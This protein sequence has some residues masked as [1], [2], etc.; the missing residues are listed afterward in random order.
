MA[1]ISK[2][3]NNIRYFRQYNLVKTYFDRDY[4][5]STY[6]DV[7]VSGVNPVWHYLRHGWLEWRNPSQFFD[8]KFYYTSFPDCGVSGMNPFY[9]YLAYGKAEGRQAIRE[10]TDQIKIPTCFHHVQDNTFPMAAESAEHIMVIV[11][12]EHNEMSGGIFSFFS[13]AKATYNLRHK[14]NYLVLLMTRPNPRNETY[15]RQ[16]NFRNSEDVFRFDQ[17]TRCKKAKTIYIHI[18]EYAAP[19]FVDY[20]DD[21]TYMFLKSRER[22]YINILNQKIDIMPNKE[23]LNTLRALADELTQSVAHHAY[24]G[25]KFAARYDTPMLLLPAYTDLSEYCSIPPEEKENLIIYSP[26]SSEYKDTVINTIK[27][28]LPNYQLQEIKGITFET[29]MDLATR[30]KYSITFG[31]GFDGYLAQ[32]IHQ[33]GVSF[34]VYN[35]EFFPTSDILTFYNIFP[36]SDSMIND[37][38]DR[39]KTLDSDQDLYKETNA[40]MIE[41]YSKLYSKDDYLNKIEMLINR[42]F[43]IYPLHLIENYNRF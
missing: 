17:I 19:S 9:H 40:R 15:L 1:Y 16:R 18:P 20:M 12:P 33:G 10:A 21:K 23:E 3:I 2:V 29:Y 25:Q 27:D 41:L 5:L 38:V 4:Y 6:E 11:V 30:C 36:T 8:T 34:A 43:E 42:Q 7:K 14:H 24:F 31:E 37:I 39:I 22:I 13:I 35:E 32:P 26:D 28:A